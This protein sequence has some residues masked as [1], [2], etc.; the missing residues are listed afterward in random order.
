MNF[1]YSD[2]FSMYA[3]HHTSKQSIGNK[4]VD[5]LK[6]NVNGGK[7]IAI[8]IGAGN[9]EITN[10]LADIFYRV[11]AVERSIELANT[12]RK[13]KRANINVITSD[14]LNYTANEKY[15]LVL[16]SYLL[17]SYY[18]SIK[19]VEI[20]TIVD[21]LVANDGVVLGVTYLHDCAWD[22]F[23]EI[24]CNELDKPR[25]G[26]MKNVEGRL[27]KVGYKCHI[28]KTVDSYIWGNTL[29]ELFLNLSFFY[30]ANITGYLE[31]KEKYMELLEKYACTL[32]DLFVINVKE[33]IFDI[34]RI[35]AC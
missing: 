3:N 13:K 27:N 30:K 22:K 15:N 12:I 7:D 2:L 11:D 20:M 6:S 21:K 33:A 34:K 24:V 18:E 1:L 26:G 28:L 9:G 23:S 31:N 5:L 35:R 32:N 14:I 29:E 4:L 17:D 8:D 25:K 19:T 10:Y 16:M